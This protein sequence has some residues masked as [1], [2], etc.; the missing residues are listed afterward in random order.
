M[1]TSA[2]HENPFAPAPGATP[3]ALVG[4]EAELASIQDACD[5]VI[6]HSAP[7]PIAILGLRGLGKT[8][9]LNVVRQHTPSGIHLQLEVEAGIPLV[10]SVRAVLGRLQSAVEPKL[11][12]V[13]KAIESALRQLPM[14]AFEL[15][16]HMGAITL[17]APEEEHQSANLPLGQAVD[18]LN[19]A[20]A[21]ARRYLVITIDEVQD[22]DVV[23]FRSLVARVHQTASSR[24][25]ILLACAGL[26]DANETFRKLRTYA[27]RWDRFDLG[28]LSRAETV[29]AIRV[30]IRRAGTTI[31]DRAVD[32]L[33]NESAGYPFFVQKY[34]S[35]A[36]NHHRGNTISFA[37]VQAVVPGVRAL[38]E[39]LFYS[40]DFEK[41]SPRE[42]LFSKVLA[43]LG[44][45]PHELGRVAESL[46]VPSSAISSIRSNLIKKGIIFVPGAGRVEFR[47]PLA[48]RY[49]REHAQLFSDAGTEAYK[50]SLSGPPE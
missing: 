34:A 40:E 5:R 6:R 43:D 2:I 38:V 8:V 29:E 35:A 42:R 46:G 13:G 28:F 21:A 23:G 24:A 27:R 19:E 31:D 1:P 25:P 44:E 41:L 22:A 30:P 47:M 11:K 15:P 16:Q 9:L 48:D 20:V 37:D 18:I 10:E 50:R 39:K 49:V 36:W 32:L 4:R 7:T 17:V 3:P 12:R 14:P 33:A 26:P 45:G